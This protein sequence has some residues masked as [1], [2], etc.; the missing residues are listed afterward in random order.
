[1][2]TGLGPGRVRF[3]QF[4]FDRATGELYRD[5]ARIHLQDQPSQILSVLLAKPGDIVTR[6]RLRECL[7]SAD[8]FVDYE[9]GLNT[10]VK[11]LRQ[12]L[13]D[14]A[15][16][17]VF[18]ET[19]ARRGYR[20]IGHAEA[21]AIQDVSAAPLPKASAIPASLVPGWQWTRTSGLVAVVAVLAVSS[22][23]AWRFETRG[24]PP[25]TRDVGATA[26]TQLAVIPFHVLT[27]GRVEG[28]YLGTGLADAI[29]TRL[30]GTRRIGVRPTSAVLPFS[31]SSASPAA[32]AAALG[33]EH[34]VLGTVQLSEQA[35]RVTVQLVAADGVAVW[36]HTYAEPRSALVDLQDRVAEQV[37]AALRI[38]LAGPDRARLHTRY[39]DN[40]AAYDFY[41]RGRSLLLNYTEANM[42]AAITQFEQALALD[43]QYALARAG[44]ATACAWF[45]VRYA[46]AAEAVDW[47]KR[48]DVEARLALEEDGSLADAHLAIA[49]AA[50]TVY[51]GFEWHIVL[52]RSAAALALDPSLDL[53]HVARMRAYYHLGLFEEAA[54]EGDAA[55]RLNPG[56]N[57]ELDRL[58]V[59]LLLFDGHFTEAVAR[60]EDLQAQTDAAAVR[61]YLGLA[62]YYAGDAI[63]GRAM[64]ATTIRSDVPD[65]RAQAS[66]ASIE[67]ATGLGRDARARIAA[68]VSGPDL[69]HH[70]AYSLG[71]AY[72]QLGDPAASLRWLERAADS[73]FPCYPWFARDALLDPLRANPRFVQ[74]LARLKDAHDDARRRRR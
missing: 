5:G 41:L 18:I 9:H 43:P 35:Y 27:A 19:L 24:R 50:G 22:G 44:I 29:T 45:S 30:A 64:L 11:K 60:A 58:R 53:A 38:E 46:H 25:L 47:G 8:T 48:A 40:P 69:D 21:P 51:G 63:G 16:A 74:L 17:P 2:P 15:E 68:I 33:V 61:H 39:T 65:P 37:V 7:W 55:A 62:R 13:G 56:R 36:G 57:V 6:D 3:A 67:A 54:R 59:A 71:A 66:L 34:L 26:T 4:D 10:A 14:S 12:A 49:N 32:V 31:A 28:S 23:L 70:V 72:A 52:D 73:G 1:M 20:F 42:R